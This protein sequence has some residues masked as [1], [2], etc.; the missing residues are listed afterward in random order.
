MS[1]YGLYRATFFNKRCERRF[2]ITDSKDLLHLDGLVLE[3][4]TGVINAHNME[5]RT[6]SIKQK[7]LI[8]EHANY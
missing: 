1:W 5:D 2:W 4:T 7:S 6:L 8:K 3:I